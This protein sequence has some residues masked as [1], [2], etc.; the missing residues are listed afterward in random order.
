MAKQFSFF[1]KEQADTDTPIVSVNQIVQMS[2]YNDPKYVVYKTERFN[3]GFNYHLINLDSMSFQI[4]RRIRPLSEKFGI[5]IYFDENNPRYMSSQEVAEILT[6]VQVKEKLEQQ[7][8]E[9]EKERREKV[10]AIGRE[11]L[12]ESLPQDAQAIIV[13]RLKQDDSDSHTDY[14]ASSVQQTMI[15]GFSKHKRDIFSEM[16]KYANNFEGTAYLAE[17][18]PNYEHREKYSMGAGYYL[19]ESGYSGWIIEKVKI[20]NRE[21]IIND[22]AYIAGN[23]ENIYLKKNACEVK[24]TSTTEIKLPSNGQ[25]EIADYS[26]KAIALFGDTKPIKDLLKAIGGKFNPRLTHNEE[27]RAGWIFAIAKREEVETIINLK[28]E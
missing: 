6:K 27:K 19:G 24:E 1:V 3:S 13:A 20:Y 4:T 7:Q 17:N 10:S 21:Y 18:N 11:W 28:T 8:A 14:F 26:Q 15:L 5:G 16:R 23:H 9:Q 25:F 12:Q 22:F 2:G